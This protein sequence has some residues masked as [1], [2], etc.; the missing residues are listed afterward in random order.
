GQGNIENIRILEGY[1][2]KPVILLNSGGNPP[3]PDYTGGEA[4]AI[5]QKLLGRGAIPAKRIEE[6]LQILKKWA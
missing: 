5:I 1:R 6:V 3:F 2:D 4:E